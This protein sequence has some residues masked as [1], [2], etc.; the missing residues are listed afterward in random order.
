MCD[1]VYVYIYVCV[2]VSF[3]LYDLVPNFV[4]I[5]Q[6]FTGKNI[7]LSVVINLI[8]KEILRFYLKINVHFSHKYLNY[9]VWFF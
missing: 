6:S 5:K 4:Y 3:N 2:C 7:L 8:F 1:Y 9:K